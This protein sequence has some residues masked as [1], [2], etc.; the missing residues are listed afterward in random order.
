[1]L[2]CSG[3]KVLARKRPSQQA[4]AVER[5]QRL[6]ATSIILANSPCWTANCR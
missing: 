2:S 4:L 3:A 5:N 1:M 6:L